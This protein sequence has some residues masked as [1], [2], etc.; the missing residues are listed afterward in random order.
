MRRS[1]IVKAILTVI[2]LIIL[3]IGGWYAYQRVMI[4]GTSSAGDR[5]VTPTPAA[6][7][8]QHAYEDV[9][10]QVD[11]GPRAPGDPGHDKIVAWMQ[12][13]LKKAGWNVAI[14]ASTQMGHPVQNVV[15]WRGARPSNMDGWIVFGAHY[16]SR[17]WAD[18][19]RDPTKIRQP[20]PAANDGG[21]GV[22]V[23]LEMARVLSPSQSNK[24][25]L[26]FFDAEDDGD[27]PGWDWLLGSRAYVNSLQGKPQAAIILDMIGDADLNIYL[28]SNSNSQISA[29]IWAEAAKLGYTQF[30][31]IPKW[32]ME[33]DHTPFLQAGIPAV[34]IIDFDYPYWHTTQDTLDKVSAQSLSVVGRTVIAWL[35]T[36]E[37]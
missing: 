17:M 35:E 26:V 23:L 10:T 7:D 1:T 29:A 16:D 20:V 15:A 4:W 31:N 18:Q 28:E 6:F 33:D 19:D 27:I 13:E 3:L 22:A 36:V 14:D 5:I 34:D 30:I 24:V 9:K 12:D 25:Q 8:G 37:R 32:S 21:S 2:V 11:F